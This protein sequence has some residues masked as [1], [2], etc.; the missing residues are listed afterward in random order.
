MPSVVC[1]DKS[2]NVVAVG[3][4]ANADTNPDLLG[5]DGLVTAEW[6]YQKW[7]ALLT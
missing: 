2:G 1:Y 6:F 5:V 3:L 7:T 4:E